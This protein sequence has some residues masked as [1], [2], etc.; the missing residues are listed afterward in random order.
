MGRE[1]VD[2]FWDVAKDAVDDIFRCTPYAMKTSPDCKRIVE[3]TLAEQERAD[4]VAFATRE[5][6]LGK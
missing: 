3:K 5:R 4:S 1:H 2:V 6:I